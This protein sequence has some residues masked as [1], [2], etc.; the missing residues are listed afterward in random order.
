VIVRYHDAPSGHVTG[1][2]RHDE[3]TLP[4]TRPQQLTRWR[5]R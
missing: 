3:Q 2:L 4:S 5:R 1:M